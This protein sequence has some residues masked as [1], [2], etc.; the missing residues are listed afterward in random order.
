MGGSIEHRGRMKMSEKVYQISMYAATVMVV[1]LG[2]DYMLEIFKLDQ[3]LPQI[4]TI[5]QLASADIEFV[6]EETRY[7]TIKGIYSDSINNDVT[8]QKIFNRTKVRHI[9]NGT[10]SFCDLSITESSQIDRT[11]NL[12]ALPSIYGVYIQKNDD[13]WQIDRIQDPIRTSTLNLFSSRVS[14]FRDPL[15]NMIHK[16]SDVGLLEGWRKRY[17]MSYGENI[18][19][20]QAYLEEKTPT[21]EISPRYQLQPILVIG[22]S[23][24]IITLIGEIIWKI[25]IEKTPLGRAVSAFY[26]ESS[27]RP[28]TTSQLSARFRNTNVISPT[29]GSLPP[30]E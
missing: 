22:F 16:Y 17:M 21:E 8:L 30:M 15:Q 14:F 19:L 26:R 7:I 23:I 28:A 10:F 13:R 2:A 6:M 18:S 24:S 1:T 3:D 5:Q 11:I 25:Y 27:S 9:D 29:Y 4:R 20:N 12:C